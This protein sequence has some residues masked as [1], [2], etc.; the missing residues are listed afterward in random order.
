MLN[1][2]V[3]YVHEKFLAY[4]LE[5]FKNIRRWS[6][7]RLWLLLQ[8]T[9]LSTIENYFQKILSHPPRL[10]AR[11]NPLPPKNSKSAGPLLSANTG[12]FSH[13]P[14]QKGREDTVKS[15]SI[16]SISLLTAICTAQKLKFSNKDFFSKWDQIRSFL[17]IWPH[18]LKKSLMENFIFSAVRVTWRVPFVGLRQPK[19]S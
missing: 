2:W 19:K 6:T 15:T 10:P 17:R 16:L 13:L 5:T 4:K 1:W 7:L 14:L 8:F 12:N 18:L 9:F 11:K 3:L